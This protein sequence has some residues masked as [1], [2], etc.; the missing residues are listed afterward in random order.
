MVEHPQWHVLVPKKLERK[1]IH[2]LTW[3]KPALLGVRHEPQNDRQKGTPYPGR[4]SKVQKGRADEHTEGVSERPTHPQGLT[5]AD[6]ENGARS[7][8]GPIFLFPTQVPPESSGG[9]GPP[10]PGA[11]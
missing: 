9:S 1:F 6:E 11:S 3:L 8:E 7:P 4:R 5:P 10:S 2:L